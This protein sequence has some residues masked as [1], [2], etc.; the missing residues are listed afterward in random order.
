MNIPLTFANNICKT[1]FRKG[2]TMKKKLFGSLGEHIKTNWVII[3]LA[4][5]VVGAGALSFY[6]VNDINE[7]LDNQSV[8]DNDNVLE[9]N[10]I[11][12]PQQAEDVQTEAENVPIKPQTDNVDTPAATKP[13]P[14]AS[15]V[16]EAETGKEFVLPVDGKIFAAFSG[17]ELVYNQT[18]GDWRT[19]NGIDIKA[20]A[21]S[22]V[23]SGCDGTVENVYN[24]GML[25]YVVEVTNGNYTVRYC[26]LDKNVLVQKGDKLHQNQPIGTV[27]EIPLEIAEESHIHLEIVKDGQYKNPDKY[28]D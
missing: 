4:L 6:T 25:G 28:L 8:P 23:K 16:P 26:G 5:C 24:D 11:F 10:D 14:T 12:E 17:D 18:M 21:G 22:A 13:A 27:G 20:A 1:N 3:V 15:A 2:E 19:H 9:Q 7:R